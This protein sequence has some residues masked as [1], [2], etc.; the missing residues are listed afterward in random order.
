[1]PFL[2]QMYPAD[3]CQT[4][5]LYLPFVKHRRVLYFYIGRTFMHKLFF[6]IVC[7]MAVQAADDDNTQRSPQGD[8]SFI[9]S[10]AAVLVAA[11]IVNLCTVWPVVS[12]NVA[13]RLSDGWYYNMPPF[14]A[15]CAGVTIGL[16]AALSTEQLIDFVTA[17]LSSK[18]GPEIVQTAHDLSHN[19]IPI[20]MFLIG[21][22]AFFAAIPYQ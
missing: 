21:L 1:M 12:H 9:K 10:A 5:T 2:L 16:L 11:K 17:H 7:S 22:C 8:N 14:L 4:L 3:L 19:Y 20:P 6:L 13:Y 15:A 18:Y